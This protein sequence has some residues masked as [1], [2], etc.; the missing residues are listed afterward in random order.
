TTGWQSSVRHNLSQNPAV[1]KVE[2]EGKGW[3]WGIV[4]GVNVDKERKKRE[5]SH[6][7]SMPSG[8]G[9]GV[10]VGM[11]PGI[12]SGLGGMNNPFYRPGLPINMPSLMPGFNPLANGGNP[13]GLQPRPGFMPGQPPPPQNVSLPDIPRPPFHTASSLGQMQAR[14]NS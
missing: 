8:V 4:E 9:V 1:K 14:Q 6:M 5:I 3:L 13:L 10:G 11:S 12:G 2:R 7:P